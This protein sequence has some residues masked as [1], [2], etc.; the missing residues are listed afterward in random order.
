MKNKIILAFAAA[1]LFF[2][3]TQ[4][5]Y[6]QAQQPKRAVIKVNPLS[7][8]ALTGSGFLEYAITDNLSA[9]LGASV[10]GVSISNIKFKGYGFTPE[11][12]YYF[13]ENKVA[14]MG[15]YV[16]GYG[17]IRSFKLTVEKQD[18]EGRD[19]SA[20]YNPVGA[21]V[22]IGNQWVFNSGFTFDVF[23]GAGYNGGNLKV[24][25]GTEEDFDTGIIG[26]M[27]LGGGFSV[28]PGITLGYNF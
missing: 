23:L 6:A 12:R 3:P 2:I 14:P 9:Q 8:F 17:R 19:Y 1:A 28:R 18:E 7:A 26:D 22:A 10:T 15:P 5:A 16:A 11:V 20:T 25:V 13:S 24:N 4:Q 27:I 21:G